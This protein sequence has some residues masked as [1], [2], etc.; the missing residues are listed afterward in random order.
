MSSIESKFPADPPI[1]PETN[2]E[3]SIQIEAAAELNKLTIHISDMDLYH[4]TGVTDIGEFMVAENETVGRG[5]YFTSLSE[6]TE[7][8]AK[9]RARNSSSATPLVY[10]VHIKDLNLL[11]L[12]TDENI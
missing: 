3:K 4:G 5:V 6:D 1:R 9:R 11:D 7:G 10:K 12:T 8:Y 2:F